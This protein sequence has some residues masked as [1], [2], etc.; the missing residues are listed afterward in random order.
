TFQELVKSYSKIRMV[1]VALNVGND[2]S[3]SRCCSCKSK[4]LRDRIFQK[5][6]IAVIR[7]LNHE[8]PV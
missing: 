4:M 6:L 1:P 8:R 3:V 7:C 2:P 5:G